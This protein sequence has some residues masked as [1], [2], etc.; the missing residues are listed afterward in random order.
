MPSRALLAILGCLALATLIT[1]DRTGVVWR[2]GAF[3][4]SDDAAR[5]VQVRQW[6]GGQSWY[7]LS[8]ARMDPPRGM[9]MHWSR[10][11]D[12]P[13]A[14][15]QMLAQPFLGAESAERLAR[16]IF[17][18]AL[19]VALMAA[20]GTAATALGAARARV[21]A[22]VF[23]FLG[24][25]FL[26]QFVPG[27]IDHHAPQ[28]LLVVLM[29]GAT[30]R[31]FDGSLRAA[32]VAGFCAAMSLAIS[33][34]NVPTIAIVGASYPF[35]FVLRGN[36]SRP[37]MLAFA[38][39]FAA[40]LIALFFA[41]VGPGHRGDAVCDAYSIA[42]FS[43]GIAGCAVLGTLG[44]L[45]RRLQSLRA[46]I[47]T[48]LAFAPLPLLTVVLVAPKCLGDP[49][50]GLDPLVRELWLRNVVEVEPLPAFLHTHFWTGLA[51][52]LPIVSAFVVSV[53]SSWRGDATDRAKH[54]LLAALLL[55][56][57]AS[58]VW[59]IRMLSTGLPLAAIV[60]A[61]AILRC[62]DR[63]SATSLSRAARLCIVAVVG[64]VFAP[65]PLAFALPADDTPTQGT[66]MACLMP[67]ALA[68]LAALLPSTVLGPIDLGSHILAHTPHAAIAA[69]YHRDNVGNRLSLEAFLATPDAARSLIAQSSATLLA[70][71]P[72]M[73]Q[74]KMLAARAPDGLAAQLLAG[75]TPSW[76]RP[77]S[78]GPALSVFA[79]A[80]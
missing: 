53:A 55:A 47:L 30:L 20:C 49:F 51:L 19:C 36:T 56:C 67:D 71:C 75:N 12:M 10:V 66:G 80:R 24:A 57:L 38:G 17:P 63:L 1:L 13:L 59:G 65:L 77:I 28:I 35:V 54:A 37:A 46:R 23:C 25:P 16:L 32:L 11:V 14:A 60:A 73:T 52:V 7:D 3:F 70:V 31:A 64:L 45:S 79:I 50:T 22:I 5:A 2:T 26:G 76:L 72:G 41:T 15:L 21:P 9:F 68:P 18:A 29:T 48:L 44:T 39:G 58:S 4:D 78:R 61:P 69:P 62:A 74:M 6:L 8:I 42:H 43:G 40:S 33:L 27:R 34:E